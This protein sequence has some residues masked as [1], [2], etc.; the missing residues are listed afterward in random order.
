MDLG[1]D[2]YIKQHMCTYD[3]CLFMQKYFCEF[4][5]WLF[6]IL[7]SDSGKHVFFLCYLEYFNKNV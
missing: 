4:L 1:C 2:F 3:M 5:I 7:L 6:K